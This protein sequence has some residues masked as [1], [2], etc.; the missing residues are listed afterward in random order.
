[1]IIYINAPGGLWEVIIRLH[2]EKSLYSAPPPPLPNILVTKN[3]VF[4]YI[5]DDTY[6]RCALVQDSLGRALGRLSI[7]FESEKTLE[8]GSFGAS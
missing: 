6:Q 2:N 3:L 7:I 8:N 5:V 4:R 1:M